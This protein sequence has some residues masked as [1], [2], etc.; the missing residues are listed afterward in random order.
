MRRWL[1][2]FVFASSIATQAQDAPVPSGQSAPPVQGPTFRTGV[3]VLTI[4]V[5]AVDSAGRPV[6]D[7]RAPDFVVRIDGQPRRVVSVEAVRFDAAA[8]R[9]EL[10]AQPFESFFTTNQTAPSARLIVLAV[11]QLNIQPGSVRQLLQ[12]ASRFLDSLSPLDRVAFFAYP[13]PGVSV[14]FTTDRARVRKAMETVVGA[15][16]RFENKFNIGLFEAIQ[17]VLRNNEVMQDRVIARECRR[18]QGQALD[19]CMRQVLTEMALMVNRVRE[20]RTRSLKG[21]EQ[22]LE[23]LALVD[24]P[25]ALIMMSEGLVLDDPNDV[26][27]IVRAS[28]RARASVNVLMMDVQRGSDV[29]RGAV[30]PPTMTEDRDLQT[31]GLRELAAASRGSLYNVFGNGT[32]IFDRLASELSAYYLIG[33]EEEPGDRNDRTHRIDI[34]VRRQGVQLRSRRAFILAQPRRAPTPA[35]RLTDLLKAPFGVSELPLRV[36]TFAVQD[37]TST[38]VRLLLAADVDQAGSRAG[39]FNI[40]WVLLDADGRVAASAAERR[41]LQPSSAGSGALEFRAEA[42]VDPGIYSLRLGVVDQA[43]RRG[44]LVREVNAWKLAGEDFAVADLV[45]GAPPR[46][47]QVLLASVEPQLDTTV[48][49]LVEL[50][51]TNAATFASTEVTFE[52]AENADAPALLTA[53]ADIVDGDRPTSRAAQAV[54]AAQ[55]LPP[56]HYVVRARIN[57]GGTPAG[58]LTRPFVLTAPAAGA[59]A[60]AAAR[61][62]LPELTPVPSFDR[63]V[64]LAPAVIAEMLTG[65]E[66]RSPRLEAAV[67]EA[68]AGRY[69]AASLEA[70]SE[71]D[72]AAAAFLKGLDFYVKG[73][74]EQA[75][76]QLN[77]AAGPRREFFP[78]AFFLGA[79]FAAT[80]RDRDAASA[81]QLAIGTETRRPLTYT[82]FADARLR[83]GQPQSV[84][85]VLQPVWQQIPTDD[86][87][88]QRLAR[89]L[90]TTGRFADALP[91]LEGLLARQPADQDALLSAIAAQYEAADRGN[92]ALTTAERTRLLAWSRAYTGPQRA[93]VDRYVDALR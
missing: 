69:G 92:R 45:V 65:I 34:E 22:L 51:A 58:L 2:I 71:G 54:M 82:L 70:L 75:A 81:W 80:G 24:A 38:K 62:A 12:S 40:G 23:S 14:D 18:L 29:G 68:R 87:I 13:A 44:A 20:D 35:E 33:V 42:L 39:D 21:L 66:R 74:F 8:I 78:A 7:L 56:G 79:T 1:A 50:Y 30:M 41:T 53:R 16:Q 11:D 91:V 61:M 93:L 73:Q 9:R 48:A 89:A 52:V 85:D 27:G 31:N 43:G 60:P 64:T 37:G 90:I 63:A 17:S 84:I 32:P 4:D 28:S 5:S 46:T 49:A 86:G 67:A 6:N 57:R 47:G 77:V 59:A 26:D 76:T 88:A 36:T 10:A 19:E 3:D 83:D 15:A 55:A 25:K 72:Q